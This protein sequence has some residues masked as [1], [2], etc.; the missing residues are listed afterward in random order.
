MPIP[1]RLTPQPARFCKQYRT[2][3]PAVPRE[4]FSAQSTA[5][6]LT[7]F[8]LPLPSRKQDYTCYAQDGD[9]IWYGA[10][11]GLTRYEPNAD[12]E[13]LVMQFFA[14]DR[15]LQDN[16]VIALLPKDGGLW[17]R[18]ETGVTRIETRLI[19]AEEKALMLL[20]ESQRI[21]D[22][23]G[24]YSQRTLAVP[25]DLDSAVPYGHSDNDGGFTAGFAVGELYHYAVNK[26]E[27]G[28]DH[29]E[30]IEARAAAVRACEACLLL[31]HIHGRGDGF[32]ARTYMC[33]DEPVP[34]DGVYFRLHGEKAT[35]I[36]TPSTRER[37]SFA[38]M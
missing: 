7:G 33:P 13:D 8:P 16:Y 3:D 17:V 35:C 11:T 22:R 18:T 38:H 15:D 12:R 2:E 9:V 20:H 14:A 23:R 36:D 4:L 10:T 21:V 1:Y 32:L 31:M 24:M 37:G 28:T 19:G 29:P 27:K 25:R 26:R 34:E 30:T 5:P 6:D